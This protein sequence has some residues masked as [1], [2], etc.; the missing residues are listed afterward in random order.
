[1][2]NTS[3]P[4]LKPVW[5][6]RKT[7]PRAHRQAMEALLWSVCAWMASISYQE[8]ATRMNL[9]VIQNYKLTYIYMYGN[10]LVGSMVYC[11]KK[12]HYGKHYS[13]H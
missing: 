13:T 12:T 4:S 5:I 10:S 11:T 8:G 2:V 1:M 7:A 3:L 9:V 6:V